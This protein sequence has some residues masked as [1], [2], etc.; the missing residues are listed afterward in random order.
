MH[1]ALQSL[2]ASARAVVQPLAQQA[3]ISGFASVLWVAG[4]AG[5]FGAALVGT[6]MRKPIPVLQLN[7]A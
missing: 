1:A 3:F 6:L 4:F 2:D 5:L 7:V